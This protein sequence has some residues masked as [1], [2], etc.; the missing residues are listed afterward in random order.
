MTHTGFLY[1]LPAS[2]FQDVRLLG[3]V[4]AAGPAPAAGSRCASADDAPSWLRANVAW[5]CY[6]LCHTQAPPPSTHT[7]AC[8]SEPASPR[9]EE[10]QE[11][12]AAPSPQP[13]AARTQPAAA[14][15][16]TPRAPQPAAWSEAG[17]TC[18]TCG[19][20]VNGPG[21]ATA[22]EQRQHF[23]TDWHRCAMCGAAKHVRAAAHGASWLTVRPPEL[24]QVQSAGENTHPAAP[25]LAT[26]PSPLTPSTLY[27]GTM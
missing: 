14:S 24:Q 10:Q 15:P 1:T 25:A 20:G 21:F 4:G 23:K 18:I 27:K 11:A 9:P 17:A 6:Q 7:Y 12:A 26:L 3:D 2:L 22:A 19:I 16:P 5:F 8:Y 13:A